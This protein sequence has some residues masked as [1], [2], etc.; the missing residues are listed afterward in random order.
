MSLKIVVLIKQVPDTKRILGEAM[1]EDGT[2]NRSALAAIFNPEDLNALEMALNLKET[3]GGEVTVLTM[4]PPKAADVLREALYRGADRVFLIT[5]RKFAGADTLATSYTLTRAVQKI[6]PDF[7]L[8]LCGRQAIDGDTAQVGPQT[9][10]KLQIPHISYVTAIEALADRK[11]TL[12]RMIENGVEWVRAPLPLL[13]TVVETANEPRYPRAKRMLRFKNA[14][15]EL[16]LKDGLTNFPEFAEPDSL[17]QYL[18][19]RGLYIPILTATDLAVDEDRIGLNGSPTKVKKID[20]VVLAGGELKLF[21]NTSNSLQ[22]LI[23][24]LVDDYIIS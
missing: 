17:R 14:M 23:G 4:G 2:V 5:D 16:E 12:K 11:L 6:V 3:R 13:L 15:C 18:T 8:V 10:E 22:S 24:I 20:S 19:N 1:K 21:E 9:A 7:D